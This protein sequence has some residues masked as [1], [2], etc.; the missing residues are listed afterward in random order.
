MSSAAFSGSL[1]P[2][3][4]KIGNGPIRSFHLDALAG[5]VPLNVDLDVVLSVLAGAI[6]ASLRRRL[7]NV[8]DFVD[9]DL[10]CQVG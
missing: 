2:V 10:G 9:T 3:V 5:A 4:Y 8:P 6:C 7:W 1:R